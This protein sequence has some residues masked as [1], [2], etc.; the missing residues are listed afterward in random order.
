MWCVRLEIRF[1][2]YP[3][4]QNHHFLKERQA[5]QK[6]Q[7][8]KNK[9]PI[10]PFSFTNAR[11]KLAYR[12]S[13]WPLNFSYKLKLME[14]EDRRRTCRQLRFISNTLCKSVSIDRYAQANASAT[15][16]LSTALRSDT[17]LVIRK[18]VTVVTF[19]PTLLTTS[20]ILIV[21]HMIQKFADIF[22]CL[23][24]SYT[25]IG[26][27]RGIKEQT[28]CRGILIYHRIS[29]SGNWNAPSILGGHLSLIWRT[30]LFEI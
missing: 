3:E 7:T 24:R 23:S 17:T 25:L 19:T 13:G 5:H 11:W 18:T 10:M 16:W 9:N 20:S 1:R 6:N 2:K 21:S 27:N 22:L 15:I 4:H 30:S 28:D 8:L 12:K 14:I 29:F 26:N